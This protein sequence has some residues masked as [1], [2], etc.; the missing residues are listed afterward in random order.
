MKEHFG[1]HGNLDSDVLAFA[2][3]VVAFTDSDGLQRS[4]FQF[5]EIS[6]QCNMDIPVK[7]TKVTTFMVNSQSAV[8]SV[9]TINQSTDWQI[10]VQRDNVI[11]I[12]LRQF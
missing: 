5:Q 4:V 12:M 7:Q 2:D 10:A 9:Y 11:S 1:N 3:D 8:Q 6:K